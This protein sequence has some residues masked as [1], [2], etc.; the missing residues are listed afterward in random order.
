MIITVQVRSDQVRD[1]EFFGASALSSR[2][3]PVSVDVNRVRQPCSR[4]AD[5]WADMFARHTRAGRESGDAAAPFIVMVSWPSCVDS[6]AGRWQ[7]EGGDR[8]GAGQRHQRVTEPADDG[9]GLF[10]NQGADLHFRP[11]TSP[12]MPDSLMVCFPSLSVTERRPPGSW[13]P[14]RRRARRWRDRLAAGVGPQLQRA[15]R[16][17]DGGAPGGAAEAKA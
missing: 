10:S 14:R 13:R 1:R 11:P 8:R 7:S 5:H 16:E 15:A 6:T 2:M 12:F 17:W 9:P 3:S 4:S